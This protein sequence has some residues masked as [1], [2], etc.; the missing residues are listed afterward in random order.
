[1]HFE[2]TDAVVDDILFYMEN[3]NGNFVFDS[4][5]NEVV[6][7]DEFNEFADFENIDD[8]EFTEKKETDEERFYKLPEWTSVDGFRLMEHFTGSLKNPPAKQALQKVLNGGKGVFRGFKNVLSGFPE[9]EK[10]WFSY[11]DDEMKKVV[12]DW[13]NTLHDGWQLS[14]L[15]TEPEE[16][17]ELVL[18]DFVIRKSDFSDEDS[19]DKAST[20]LK[21]ELLSTFQDVEK[22]QSYTELWYR[23]SIPAEKTKPYFMIAETATGDFAG[24]LQIN[25]I[26]ENLRH[27]ANLAMLYVNPSFRGLGVGRTL[28]ERGLQQVK[29]SGIKWVFSANMLLP[30]NFISVLLRNGF[31]KNGS[32]Y[33]LNL[34]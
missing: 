34:V 15:G 30:D 9:V 19:I 5:T 33:I 10:L 11:K 31:E 8:P 22:A 32:G 25:P 23:Q 29:E 28:L 1:M 7:T 3:Q 24:V 4:V 26:S 2:L 16:N 18:D 17:E 12:L 6:P 14:K 13:F 21:A 27:S 20:D